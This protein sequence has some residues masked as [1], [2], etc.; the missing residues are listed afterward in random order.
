MS[1]LPSTGISSPARRE[2]SSLSVAIADQSAMPEYSWAHVRPCSV[3]AA[4]P[5][6]TPIRAASR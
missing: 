3:I 5:A 2:T 4:T 6:S 1:P